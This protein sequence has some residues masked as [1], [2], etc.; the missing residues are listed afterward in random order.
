MVKQ[1]MMVR[2]GDDCKAD[3]AGE[4]DEPTRQTMME[5]LGPVI[6]ARKKNLGP[7]IVVRRGNLENVARQ[8]MAENLGPVYD[9]S[10][11]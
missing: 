6:V 7:V 9:P 1:T 11:A 5:N 3:D 8:T 4:A 2:P 10:L